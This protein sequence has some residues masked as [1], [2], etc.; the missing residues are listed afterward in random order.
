MRFIGI[1]TCP[2]CRK[3]VN[4]IRT[5]SLKRQGEYQCPR[6]GGISNIYLSPLIYV[7]ALLAIFAGGSVYFFH[8]FVLDDIS[9]E[10]ALHVFIPF[11]VFFL[12]SLFMVYL[13]KPVIKKV[14]KSEYGRNRRKNAQ[15]DTGLP[16][17]AQEYAE[18]SGNYP[19]RSSERQRRTAAP[20][21]VSINQENFN[22]AKQQTATMN[23]IHES[24]MVPPQPRAG[25]AVSQGNQIAQQRRQPAQR[26]APQQPAAR[27]AQTAL[28]AN[29]TPREA[30]Q[31]SP[32]VSQE[33]PQQRVSQRT[34]QIQRPVEAVEQREP[35]VQRRAETQEP[36]SRQ[37]GYQRPAARQMAGSSVEAPG[38]QRP[39]RAS[40]QQ[41]EGAPYQRPAA[42]SSQR[43]EPRQRV[44]AQESEVSVERP[45]VRQQEAPLTNFHSQ[46]MQRQ[47]EAQQYASGQP[48]S[49]PTRNLFNAN[50]PQPGQPY[51]PTGQTARPQPPVNLANTGYARHRNPYSDENK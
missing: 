50:R 17:G 21:Q 20:R 38:Y 22:R 26:T 1:P 14:A 2:Y 25:Q 4:I 18:F 39:T 7:L 33:I 16:R 12:L 8:K 37:M 42:Q 46:A 23:A 44:G 15:E 13:E 51:S 30:R 31:A 35:A 24:G 40:A 41:M 5:W 32:S 45:A 19:S 29:Q 34:A 28:Q 9:L 36:V 10:T 43:L 6:C 27:Q 47:R 3:R 11:A 49:L 48:N